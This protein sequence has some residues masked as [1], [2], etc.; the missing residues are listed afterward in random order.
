[1]IKVCVSGRLVTGQ[2]P[3][4]ATRVGDAMRTMLDNMSH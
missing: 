1:M 2:N 4:S 3:N